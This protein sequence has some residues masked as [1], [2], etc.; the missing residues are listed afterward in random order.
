MPVRISFT[1]DIRAEAKKKGTPM[2][3]LAFSN[4]YLVKDGKHV[5]GGSLAMMGRGTEDYVWDIV[6]LMNKHERED[7][8]E[9][10]DQLWRELNATVIQGVREG[11]MD[12]IQLQG[13]IKAVLSKYSILEGR[14]KK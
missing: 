4:E 1:K 3:A 11:G 6:H 5:G 13:A 9:I 12:D 7:P 2:V 14:P 8:N 10:R